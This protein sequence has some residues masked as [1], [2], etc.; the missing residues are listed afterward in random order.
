[1][2]IRLKTLFVAL[3]LL[4]GCEETPEA[5]EQALQ[6]PYEL[7]NGNTTATYPE[8]LEFYRRL[9][10]EFPEVNLQ[11]L[12]ETDSGEPL[13]LVTYNP[14]GAFNFQKLGAEKDHKR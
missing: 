8:I 7:G 14:E 9:A 12:G 5:R 1:M 3:L 6:T 4:A 2:P 11:T 10:R 13:H